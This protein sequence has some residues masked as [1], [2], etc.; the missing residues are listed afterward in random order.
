M[1]FSSCLLWYYQS[2]MWDQDRRIEFLKKVQR[3]IYVRNITFLTA[4]LPSYFI[5][6]YIFGVITPFRLLQFCVEIFFCSRKCWCPLCSLLPPFSMALLLI[7][8][9]WE[10]LL[11]WEYFLTALHNIFDKIIVFNNVINNKATR[12][13]IHSLLVEGFLVFCI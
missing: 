7:K 11:L 3:R 13:Y 9:F 12:L 4:Y 6:C 10:L 2:F 5:L 1:C 8:L